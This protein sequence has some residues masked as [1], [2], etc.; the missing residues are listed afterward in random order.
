MYLFYLVLM[1]LCR[2]LLGCDYGLKEQNIYFIRSCSL[3][4]L[5]LWLVD[6]WLFWK[7]AFEIC[8]LLF[9]HWREW[10]DIV[11]LLQGIDA[12]VFWGVHWN[13]IDYFLWYLVMTC[14]HLCRI[15]F[16]FVNID[17]AILCNFSFKYFPYINL[18]WLFWFSLKSG[19]T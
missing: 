14:E 5:K 10:L 1:F 2:D 15:W 3:L 18:C 11:D 9:F 6:S 13:L 12:R 4:W 17:S 16:I 8:I 7:Y 19:K